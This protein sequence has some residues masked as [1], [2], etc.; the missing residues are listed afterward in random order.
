MIH[1]LV[2]DPDK[3][4]RLQDTDGWKLSENVCRVTPIIFTT[5]LKLLKLE[6]IN[7]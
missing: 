3:E 6:Q 2:R 5:A 4:E 7:I 1:K